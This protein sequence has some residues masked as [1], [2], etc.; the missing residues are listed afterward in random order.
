M[1]RPEGHPPDSRALINNGDCKF[2]AKVLAGS[3]VLARST[4]LLASPEFEFVNAPRRQRPALHCR[5]PARCLYDA[6]RSRASTHAD[7]TAPRINCR[8][9]LRHR[10]H[11]NH[12]ARRGRP[13]CLWLGWITVTRSGHTQSSATTLRSRARPPSFAKKPHDAQVVAMDAPITP[14]TGLRTSEREQCHTHL[15]SQ[16]RNQL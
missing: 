16:S 11:Y 9:L 5:S 4:E 13:F 14:A 10:Q 15:L 12:V 7:R 2:T 6:A 3:K 1:K 8:S